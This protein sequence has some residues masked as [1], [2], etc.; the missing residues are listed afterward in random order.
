MQ[1]PTEGEKRVEQKLQTRA[2]LVLKGHKVT[3]CHRSLS[4]LNSTKLLCTPPFLYV[5]SL[6]CDEAIYE[7]V[8]G[9]GAAP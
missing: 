2:R 4:T 5:Q 1:L 3:F 8:A 7:H 6:P 9:C